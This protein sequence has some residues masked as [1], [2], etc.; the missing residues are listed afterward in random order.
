PT[1]AENVSIQPP[2]AKPAPPARVRAVFNKFVMKDGF[3]RFVDRT[4]SPAYAEELSKVSVIGENLG[5]TPQR[6]GAPP[7]RGT[8]E[9]RGQFASGTPL[10][11]RAQI[12]SY[13]GPFYLDVVVDVADF[14]VPRLNPY[15][16]R[17][18]SWVARQGTLTATLKYHIEGDDLEALN[19]VRIDGLDLEQGGHGGEFTKRTGLPLN[20]LVSLLKDR[21]G[22]I[23][24]GIPVRGRLSSPEFQYSEAV[25]AALRNLTI[26][27]VA[28][29]FSLVGKLFFTE[30]SR[31]ESLQIDPVTFQTARAA[32]DTAGAKQLGQLATFLKETPDIRL[33]MRPVTTVADV[34]ALRRQALESRLATLGSDEAARRQA[35]VGLYTE[36]FPR[37]DPPTSD[38]ALYDE[39]A[40]ETPTPPRAL[41]ALTTDR[42][43]AV[44]EALV[45]TGVPAERLERLESRAAVESEGLPRV[46]FEIARESLYSGP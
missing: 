20:T 7:R 6:Q 25:W 26:K 31:I 15:L 33:R 21:K 41:G 42:V 24:L 46:E 29:P 39:L 10:T 30:D 37:R 43:K 40:R 19:D 17:L 32:P 1:K 14:A 35:A 2:S 3:I 22:V 45:R 12:G 11:V 5:T 36:L 4:T 9:L 8:L 28:L 44:H 27:L 23:K 38:E 16:D 13:P 34:T 18:S